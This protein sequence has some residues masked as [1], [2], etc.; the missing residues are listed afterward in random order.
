[1]ACLSSEEIEE[2]LEKVS[3]LKVK[4]EIVVEDSKDGFKVEA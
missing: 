1:L 4:E 3:E 2:M